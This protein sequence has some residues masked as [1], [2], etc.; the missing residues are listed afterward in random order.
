MAIV[1]TGIVA[2]HERRLALVFSAPLGI[3][4]FGTAPV[5]L[6]FFSVVSQKALGVSPPV[7][8]SIVVSGDGNSL[9]L[10]LGEDLVMGDTYLLSAVGV[11]A[12]AGPP[13]DASSNQIFLF[14]VPS[15]NQ[16]TEPA[17]SD[18]DV[19]LYG[20]DLV[21]NG[22]DYQETGQGDLARVSGIVNV[23]SALTRR[24]LANGL[25]WDAS[26]GPYP[27]SYVNGP[28]ASGLTLR[29]ALVTQIV[30]DDRVKSVKIDLSQTNDSSFFLITPK[31]VGSEVIGPI[32]VAIPQ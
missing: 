14:G 13:T 15:N 31:L 19:L 17:V 27:D 20:I 29:G 11:P 23:V 26:Y 4:A 12:V 6:A 9:E 3:G 21:W 8:E 18:I 10:A 24:V 25:P 16:N 1:L 28:L 7:I 22:L 30:K 2:K 5:T 32:K